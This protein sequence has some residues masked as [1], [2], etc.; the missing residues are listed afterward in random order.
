MRQLGARRFD[1]DQRW[2]SLTHTRFVLGYGYLWKVMT[3]LAA[4]Q[5]LLTKRDAAQRT[6]ILLR[7]G[8]RQAGSEAARAELLLEEDAGSTALY[9]IARDGAVRVLHERVS[10]C[11]QQLARL[12]PQGR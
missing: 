4:A 1:L 10:L 8:H 12:L 6:M 11:C 9:R 2:S 3:T 5:I 7:H